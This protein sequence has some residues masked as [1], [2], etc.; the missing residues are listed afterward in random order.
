M[1]IC[2][3][4]MFHNAWIQR[5]YIIA[6]KNKKYQNVNENNYILI[7]VPISER[8]QNKILCLIN[9]YKKK[10]YQIGS[11]LEIYI[12][13]NILLI[14]VKRTIWLTVHLIEYFQKKICLAIPIFL[15]MEILRST[16]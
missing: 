11:N 3:V 5:T 9:F 12:H 4:L 14:V 8:Q 7:Q 16:K 10:E 2:E 13:S 1:A 15:D 6:N